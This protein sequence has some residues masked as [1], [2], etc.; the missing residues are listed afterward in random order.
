MAG[1]L[2]AA[3]LAEL[4]ARFK[5]RFVGVDT[6]GMVS[7]ATVVHLL[8]TVEAYRE[9]V[10]AVAKQGGA[11]TTGDPDWSYCMFDYDYGCKDGPDEDHVTHAPSCPWMQA[12]ALLGEE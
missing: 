12:R 6:Y 1:P 4:R 8:A 10:A 3:E 9:I 7:D 5:N 2:T 11:V